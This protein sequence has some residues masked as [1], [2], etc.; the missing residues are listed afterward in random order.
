[1]DFAT[2]SDSLGSELYEID[3]LSLEATSIQHIPPP[4]P[5]HPSKRVSSSAKSSKQQLSNSEKQV[6][7]L[8]K[9]DSDNALYVTF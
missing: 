9:E 8:H 5:P 1:M 6:D 4:I 3:A 2:T 7:R